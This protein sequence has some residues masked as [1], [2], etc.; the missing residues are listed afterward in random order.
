V[1]WNREKQNY[2]IAFCILGE[3]LAYERIRRAN[4]ENP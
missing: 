3:F 2:A 1:T 4:R